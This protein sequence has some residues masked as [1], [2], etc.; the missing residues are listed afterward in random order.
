MRSS[1]FLAPLFLAASS[2]AQGVQEGI[3]PS[4]GPPEGCETT[5][6]GN[7]TIGTL[8]IGSHHAKRETAQQAA[9][10]AL[11]CTVKDGVLRDQYGRT[12][13]VVANHQFQF[14]GPPQAGAI[15]TGGFA[16]CKNDSLAIGGTTRWW[17]CNSGP[18]YN[19]Y[20]EWIGEQCEEIRIQIAF[21]DQPSSSSST[22]ASSSAT[23][24]ASSATSSDFSGTVS[25][26]SATES[27]LTTSTSHSGNATMTSGASTGSSSPTGSSSATASSKGSSASRSASSSSATGAVPAPPAQTGAATSPS[28]A[29][30]VTLGAIIAVFGAALSL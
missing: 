22:P 26:L 12:G 18:F 25:T 15:Y 9:D 11:F 6:Q 13:S 1:G 8:K 5:A 27:G 16:V 29:S 19:L 14:D 4:S 2:L 30:G 10:G 3:A 24:V 20:D 23:S 21:L 28:I 7:F 17:Q